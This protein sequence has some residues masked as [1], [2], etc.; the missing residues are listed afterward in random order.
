VGGPN[1]GIPLRQGDVTL[2]SLM[3]KYQFTPKISVQLNG[4]NLLDEDYYVLDNYDNTH[5]GEP[6][7]ASATLN[8]EF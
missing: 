7:G 1:G 3:A 4:S 5:Y 2:V 8:W 6:L